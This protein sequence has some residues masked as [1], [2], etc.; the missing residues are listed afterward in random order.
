VV[1]IHP[2]R[3]SIICFSFLCG[4]IPTLPQVTS[5]YIAVEN[6]RH[7]EEVKRK[8]GEKKKQVKDIQST[9]K[10][11]VP[12]KQKQKLMDPPGIP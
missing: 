5:I 3:Y 11:G 10:K 8:K 6:I 1:G 7:N 12:K 2:I 4:A 9:C